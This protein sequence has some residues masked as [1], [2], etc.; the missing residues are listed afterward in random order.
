MHYMLEKKHLSVK[1]SEQWEAAAHCDGF[2]MFYIELFCSYAAKFNCI[3]C[4]VPY[5][6][7]VLL[8]HLQWYS[9]SIAL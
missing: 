1:K 7:S 4:A 3:K 6:D 5:P 9:G 8:G 2:S